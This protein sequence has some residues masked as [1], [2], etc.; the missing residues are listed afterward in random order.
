MASTWAV[1]RKPVVKPFYPVLRN[2]WIRAVRPAPRLWMCLAAVGCVLGTVTISSVL[3]GPSASEALVA[4][5][6]AQQELLLAQR[7]IRDPLLDEAESLLVQARLTL[8]DRH[9]EESIVVAHRAYAKA[10]DLRR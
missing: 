9:Y 3:T 10:M 1:K 5:R 6:V 8:R 2:R 4:I 7:I